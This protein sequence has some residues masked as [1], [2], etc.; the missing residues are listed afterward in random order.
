MTARRIRIRYWETVQEQSLEADAT[1][2]VNRREPIN[3]EA[4]GADLDAL[5]ATFARTAAD[6]DASTDSDAVASDTETRPAE[7]D[8]LEEQSLEAELLARLDVIDA[9]LECSEETIRTR[10]L[11]GGEGDLV[12]HLLNPAERELGEIIEITLKTD[13]RSE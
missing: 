12:L 1:L 2:D 7:T 10:V 3:L 8:S 9:K 11:S 5:E 6:P 4:E 13:P